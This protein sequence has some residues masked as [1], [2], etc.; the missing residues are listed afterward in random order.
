MALFRTFLTRLQCV[1]FMVFVWLGSSVAWAKKVNIEWKPLNGAREYEMKVEREGKTVLSK[2]LTDPA[3]SG[4]LDAGIY[5]YQIR[6]VDQAK[7]PGE[8]TAALPLV[9]VP[10]P[11]ETAFPVDG[12][13]VVLYD[14]KAVVVLKWKPVPGISKY[15][16][17]LRQGKRHL[18]DEL[19]FGA[20]LK[21]PALQAGQY[22][23]VV[24]PIVEAS[25]R[26]PASLQ[27]RKWEGKPSEES[28]F[29]I[30][31]AKLETP[32]PLYPVET[33]LPPSDGKVKFKWKKVDGAEGYQLV[34]MQKGKEDRKIASH[35]NT[36]IA[37]V[38]G[39]G[40]FKW[41]VRALA[42]IDERQVAQAQSPESTATFKL[43]RA[44][45]F[46]EGSGYVAFSTLVAPYTY[47]VISP[48]TGASGSAGSQSLTGR[49]SGEYWFRPNFGLSVA[50]EE[51]YFGTQSDTFLRKGYEFLGKSRL[52]FGDPKLSWAIVPKF[53][54][55]GR[56]YIES[57]PLKLNTP[58]YIST[59]SGLT[60]GLDLRKQLS[61]KFSLGIKIAYFKPIWLSSNH[62]TA[63]TG[64]ASNRNFSVG[65][66]VLYWATQHWGLGAGGYLEKR[67]LSYKVDKTATGAPSN[68]DQV[69]MDGTYFFGSVLYSFGH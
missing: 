44:A 5:V 16:I 15:K 6:G 17:K 63:L 18:R 61:R 49:L 19:I 67:S 26:G 55:E 22:T 37:S 27:N 21:L 45:S 1:V 24:I 40:E 23:W 25:Q 53:G 35:E 38:P 43:D 66:Q 59:V 57:F 68:V 3:W 8:W 7:R 47:Q 60:V 36:V 41:R 32:V 52:S 48:S 51:T 9:V 20:E 50:F 2:K 31:Q 46:Y 28:E 69:F 30:D 11:P 10:K 29:V 62:A 39:E 65:A 13:K 64:D 34:L 33:M 12:Q 14:P 54:I 58:S 4:D 42:N 56:D